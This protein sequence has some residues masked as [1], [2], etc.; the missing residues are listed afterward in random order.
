MCQQIIDK[1]GIWF[2]LPAKWNEEHE[3][4]KNRRKQWEA[5]EA[6]LKRYQP[7][8]DRNEKRPPPQPKPPQSKPNPKPKKKSV[9]LKIG[10]LIEDIEFLTP[11][12]TP[13]QPLEK[14]P[15]FGTGEDA[16]KDEEFWDFYDQPLPLP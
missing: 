9:P 14:P 5:H 13:L 10:M 6:T 12:L 11:P 8:W 15:I 2:S 7:N 3:L 16:M 4:Y 1:V